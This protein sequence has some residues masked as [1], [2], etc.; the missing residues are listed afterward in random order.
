MQANPLTEHQ[1]AVIRYIDSCSRTK[2]DIDQEFK[3]VLSSKQ[4]GQAL[5]ELQTRKYICVERYTPS[6]PPDSIF[7]KIMDT[8]FCMLTP[9][10]KNYLT[11]T[12]FN[13]TSFSDIQNSTIAN[14]SPHATQT[15]NIIDQPEDIQE[16]LAELQRAIDAK[17]GSAIKKTFGYIADKSVDAAIAVAT[18]A[19][20]R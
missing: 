3:G 4:I 5:H 13:F 1:E 14:Y 7:N 15:I 12:S 17:D 16:K 10:G 11:N 2:E 18:G 6:G 9:L 20:L 8:D 19:L